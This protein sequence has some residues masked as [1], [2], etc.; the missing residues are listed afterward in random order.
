MATNV[1]SPRKSRYFAI[2]IDGVNQFKVQKV[3]RPKRKINSAEHGDFNHTISTPSSIAY[4]DATLELISSTEDTDDQMKQWLKQTIDPQAGTSGL[5]IDVKKNI[6]V[7]ELDGNGN[8]IGGGSEMWIG[9]YPTEVD[10]GELDRTSDDNI[11]AKVSLNVD[12]VDDI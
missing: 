10:P 12:R 2:E 5:P 3:T 9:C 7:R 1:A 6:V 4:D 8:A 11:M